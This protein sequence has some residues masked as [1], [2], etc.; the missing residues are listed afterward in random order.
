MTFIGCAEGVGVIHGGAV[1]GPEGISL[2]ADDAHGLVVGSEAHVDVLR[3]VIQEPM[4][5]QFI[6]QQAFL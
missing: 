2:L 5:E 3:E 1:L 6:G 4:E